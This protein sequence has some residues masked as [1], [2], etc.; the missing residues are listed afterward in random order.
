MNIDKLKAVIQAANP[1]IMELKFGC[2]VEYTYR[3]D[4]SVLLWVGQYDGIIQGFEN[5]NFLEG[6]DS[7][8][9]PATKYPKKKCKI[10]GR[11]IRLAD[12]L[13]ALKNKTGNLFDMETVIKVNQLLIKYDLKNDNLDHQSEECQKF[14]SELL[15]K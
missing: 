13:V 5:G 6:N 12:I 2:E 3:G 1:E 4:R 8:E 7:G 9:F 14:L 11:A 10:L 15:V